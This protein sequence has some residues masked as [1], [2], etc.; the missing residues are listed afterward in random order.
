M[1]EATRSPETDEASE[2]ARL[3][4]ALAAVEAARDAALA[5]AAAE[6]RRLADL[7]AAGERDLAVALDRQA[8]T[9]E[10]L[11]AISRSPGRVEP[12][13]DAILASALHLCESDTGTV[14]RLEPDGLHLAAIRDDGD[15]EFET[16]LRASS[17]YHAP[18]RSMIGRAMAERRSQREIDCRDSE[19]Y[20]ARIPLA[21]ACVEVGGFRSALWVPLLKGDEAVGVIIIFRR[22]VRSFTDKQ[23]ELV[24]AFAAQAVIAVEN[25][26]LFEQLRV[27]RDRA[28]QTLEELQEAQRNLI[29]AEKMASLGRLTAGVAH[30]I[31]NP[32]NFVNNFAALSADLLDELRETAAPA[33]ATLAGDARAEVEEI[34]GTLVGNMRKIVDHGKRADG[35]VKSMLAHSR[36]GGHERLTVDLNALIEE[37]LGLA[38]HAARARDQNFNVALE[39]DL[40]PALQRIPLVPQDITRVFLNLFDNGFYAANKRQHRD[41]DPAFRPTLRVSARDEGTGVTIRIRDN[42]IGISPE[43]R[44]RLFEPFF[45]TKPTGEGTGLGLSISYEIVTAQH[46]GTVAVESEPGVFTEFTVTLPRRGGT[47]LAQE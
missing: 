13:F 29:Q 31:K 21:V 8:A 43:A 10:I 41:A 22:E 35:I 39:R 23:I 5:D 24:E 42:G 2:L 46:G 15:P 12:V 9:A 33:F 11:D 30:E 47:G 1:T 3:A 36:D 27:A 34:I 20:L 38:Y 14:H 32:L 28:E 17:P 4:T 7:L 40:D 26:R 6:N 18:A 45:T 25:A 19:A 16:H 44:A 37:A